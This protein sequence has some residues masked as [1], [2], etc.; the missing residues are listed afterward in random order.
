MTRRRHARFRILQRK[1]SIKPISPVADP[2]CNRI[3]VGVVLSLEVRQCDDAFSFKELL[4][5]QLGRSLR[6]R[7]KRQCQW[8]GTSM[9]RR[10]RMSNPGRRHSVEAYKSLAMSK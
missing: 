8:L 4:F 2:C 10:L 3:I 1:L 6:G 9:P 7:S 5:P